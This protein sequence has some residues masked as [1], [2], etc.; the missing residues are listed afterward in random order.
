MGRD[1]SESHILLIA[2]AL[3][4]INECIVVQPIDMVKTRFQ[5]N[6]EPNLSILHSM[7]TIY[8][9]GGF[10]RFYRGFLPEMCGMIPKTSALYSSNE[11]VGR[12]LIHH[13]ELDYLRVHEAWL[14]GA[15][16]GI[17]EATVANPFQVVK[18][19]LQAKEYIGYYSNSADCIKKIIRDEGIWRLLATGYE[20]TCWRNVV[21]NGVYFSIMHEFHKIYA[22]SSKDSVFQSILILGMGGF[23]GGTIATCFNAPFDMLCSRFRSQ[24]LVPGTTPKYEYVLPSL[25][26]VFKEEGLKSCYKGF[27]PK[28]LRMG[29]GGA[30]CMTTFET[31]CYI[32]SIC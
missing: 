15:V 2:G 26:R 10:L 25:F 30:V 32:N 31:V 14:A 13:S 22:P 7:R 19:R 29:V 17:P 1:S 24:R 28:A 6:H 27:T 20:A 11:L 16:S 5:L 18:V 12:Y 3:S 21:W 23:I 9:E 4:G 8:S